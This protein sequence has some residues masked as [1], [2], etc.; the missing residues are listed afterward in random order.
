MKRTKKLWMSTAIALSMGFAT[1]F[2]AA[3]QVADVNIGSGD[4]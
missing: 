1:A 4:V 3:A 2:G